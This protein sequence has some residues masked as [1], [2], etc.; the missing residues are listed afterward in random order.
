MKQFISSVFILL[1]L[2]VAGFAQAAKSTPAELELYSLK[3]KLSNDRTGIIKNVSCGGCDYKIG[4]ITKKTQV[5]INGT[6]VD[7]LRAR[8]GAGKQAFIQF[9]RKT[10]EIVAIYFRQ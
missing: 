7:L 3:I 6:E 1:F 2:S 4:K 8:E 5:Y 9:I 10:G